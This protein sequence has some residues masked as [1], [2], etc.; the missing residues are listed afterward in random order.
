MASLTGH[1]DA[2]NGV[3]FSPDA[4]LLATSSD[5][6]TIILWNPDVAAARHR[7]CD[8][9]G[10]DLTDDEWTTYLGDRPQQPVC[11]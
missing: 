6:K 1:T 4:R 2:V 8:M 7:L 9:L 5:D 10:R 11:R 3:A